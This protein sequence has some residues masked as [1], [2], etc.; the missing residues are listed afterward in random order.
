MKN[1]L[2]YVLCAVALCGCN[3]LGTFNAGV[4]NS[5]PIGKWLSTDASSALALAQATGDVAAVPCWQQVNASIAAV[6]DAKSEIGILF[7]MEFSRAV[8]IEQ[9]KINAAC[10]PVGIVL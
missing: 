7:T 6:G 10:Q 3:T 5:T 2:I 4:A 1:T 8:A 9:A